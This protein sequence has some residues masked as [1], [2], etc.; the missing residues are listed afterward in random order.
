MLRALIAPCLILMASTAIARQEQVKPDTDMQPDRKAMLVG[1]EPVPP[2]SVACQG[3][4]SLPA[5][6]RQA[7]T[8]PSST[9]RRLRPS[10]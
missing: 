9:N 7:E 1:E 5:P 2:P 10:L 4:R 6:S 8:V 3:Y